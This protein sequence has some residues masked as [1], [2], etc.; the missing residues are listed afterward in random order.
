MCAVLCG[1]VSHNLDPQEIVA[2][3]VLYIKISE[4][5]PCDRLLMESGRM[6]FIED[7]KSRQSI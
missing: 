4:A 5:L 7:V 2:K 3:I 1:N 6:M